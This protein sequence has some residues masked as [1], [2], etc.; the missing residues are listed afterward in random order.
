MFLFR[1]LGFLIRGVLDLALIAP[2][3]ALPLAVLF[4]RGPAGE[5]RAAPHLFPVALWLFDD[6]A[7]TC[8]RN[9]VIFAI[10]V[11]CAALTIGG[12]LGWMVARRRFWGRQILRVLVVALLVVS[13]AFHALGVLGL[14]GSPRPWPWPLAGSGGV[15]QGISLESWR[16]LTLWIV[17][18]WTTLPA[19]VALVSHATSISVEQLEPTWEDAAR[20]TGAGSLRAW[21]ALSWPLVRPA[22]A[23]AA[24]LVF[25]YALV[26]PG[27]P[28]VLGLRRTI[29]FQIVQAAGRPDPFPD[30][31]VWAV[32]AGLLGL[33]GWT[34][35]RWAG[36]TPIL[37]DQ[38]T[39]A[40]ASQVARSPRQATPLFA[41][42]STALLLGWAICGWMPL[43][44]LA[45]FALDQRWAEPTAGGRSLRTLLDLPRESSGSSIPEI[46]ANSLILGLEV[47]CA[48][49]AIARLIGPRSVRT[50]PDR[51]RGGIT[52][53]IVLMPPLVQ[54]IGVLAVPWLAG[55]ATAFLIERDRWAPLANA[56]GSIALEL[57]PFHDPWLL[58]ICTVGLALVPRFLGSWR[59]EVPA[60]PAGVRSDSA[61]DAALIAGASRA[62]AR[63]ISWPWP[64]RRWLGRF[65]LVSAFAG[66]NLTPALLF[67]PWADGRTVAPAVVDMAGGPADARSQAAALALCAIAVNLAA[68]AVARV[69]SIR[70]G[71]PDLERS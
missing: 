43:V 41:F 38:G 35:W 61:I 3:V 37:A 12:A 32:M 57:D 53:P 62:R 45:R 42:S 8:A 49:L 31:A 66:T 25:L 64:G 44:G 55:L 2:V 54:G 27:A 22:A 1:W 46:L 70:R 21:K 33:A 9:S 18:I 29:A 26:E 47:G 17:W 59:G 24:A 63:G 16:G 14:L 36:G 13:P 65:V 7:W 68:L 11:A 60:D 30:A 69:T 15:T 19:A 48:T 50:F 40:A 71:A 39:M 23:R 6:F 20:L 52:Q 56:L 34:F 5:P 58:L 67:E 4:D 51:L 10:V 28:L